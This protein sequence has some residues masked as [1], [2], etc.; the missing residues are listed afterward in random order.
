MYNRPKSLILLFIVLA[1]SA[2]SVPAQMPAEKIVRDK[3]QELSKFTEDDLDKID[4]GE[5]VV[6]EL[7]GTVKR[8]VGLLGV[9]KLSYPLKFAWSGLQ[10]AIENQTKETAISYG[11]FGA[12]PSVNDL[13][14]LNFDS[15]DVMDLRQCRVGDCEWNLSEPII[16]SLQTD[17]DW[18]AQDSE[19]RAAEL[20]KRLLAD[21]VTRYMKDGEKALMVYR[22]EDDPLRLASEYSELD[23]SISLAGA[24]SPKFAEYVR[25]YPNY[26]LDGVI[27]DFDWSLVKVGLKPVFLITH[28]M[29]FETKNDRGPRVLTVSKQIFANHYFESSLGVTMLIE[30][31]SGDGRPV[32]WLVMISHTRTSALRGTFGG[33]LG[34]LI[35]NQA[36]GKLASFLSDAKKYTS[37]AAANAKAKIQREE[38]V[39]ERSSSSS[40]W[41]LWALAGIGLAIS[42]LVIFLL[43]QKRAG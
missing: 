28:T 23:P 16:R 6:T 17:I 5:H 32:T 15:G 4:K 22:D 24:E 41:G 2:F 35:K 8:E 31:D 43:L 38:A 7:S 39:E 10:R 26:E 3:I 13:A 27:N 14:D 30:E 20:L 1:L 37:L 36:K 19:K 18:K 9:L 12:S 21:Y 25:K 34:G 33:F 42:V 11:K 40:G 29:S